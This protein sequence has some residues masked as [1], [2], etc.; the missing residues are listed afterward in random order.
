MKKILLTGSTGFIGKALR[1]KLKNKFI[2]DAPQLDTRNFIKSNHEYQ[3]IFHFGAP[4]SQ[5]LFNRNLEYCVHTTIMG[6][7]NV[8]NIAKKSGAKLVYPSTGLLST[9]KEYW[10][11]YALC[12][13]LTER[14]A[15]QSDVETLGLRIFASYGPGEE[16]KREYK[17]V[18]GL[19]LDDVL[20]NKKPLIYGDGSQKRDFIYID[21]VVD[22][23]TE[24]AQ[25]H[26]GIKEIGSGQ[27][28]SF[29]EVI[30][31][32]EEITGKD[33]DPQYG[34]KPST[35]IDETKHYTPFHRTSL[36]D[37]IKRYWDYLND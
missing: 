10:N 20:N 9:P 5:V 24:Y 17:S 3:Y 25:K 26:T 13:Y 18:I 35:Y 11:E 16:H 15:K 28:T 27:S 1:K 19:F 14:I 22:L 2:I 29:N 21:D 34:D 37:G 12:K 32:M 23:I 30:R 8:L 31:I 6:F 7:I 4:S 36:K 33:I